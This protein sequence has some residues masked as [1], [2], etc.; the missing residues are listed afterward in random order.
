MPAPPTALDKM[1]AVD[2]S[3]DALL[4]LMKSEGARA[5]L[6]EM[7]SHI[8]QLVLTDGANSQGT[9]DETQIGGPVGAA[10]AGQPY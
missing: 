5:E 8:R 4:P 2:S 1:F 9:S 3:I 6:A 7:K 10:G